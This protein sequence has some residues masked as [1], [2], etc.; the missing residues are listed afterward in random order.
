M[1]GADTIRSGKYY[2]GKKRKGKKVDVHRLIMEGHIGRPLNR[3]EVVHH[4]NGDINDNRIDKMSLFISSLSS[5]N[6]THLSMQYLDCVICT[7]GL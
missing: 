3:F 1:K 4:I 7:N 6:C 5:L 2:Q